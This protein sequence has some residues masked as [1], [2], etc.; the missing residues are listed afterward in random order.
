MEAKVAG[1][2]KGCVVL[3]AVL[4][5]EHVSSKGGVPVLVRDPDDGGYRPGDLLELT[6]G[7]W[8]DEHGRFIL[9]DGDFR[10]IYDPEDPEARKM[11]DAWYKQRP[12]VG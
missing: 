9:L 4:S 3:H 12:L 8:K 5:T 11:A 2:Y 7:S 10:L 6:S 1:E